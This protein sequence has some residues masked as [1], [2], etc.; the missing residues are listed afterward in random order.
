MEA[1]KSCIYSLG[2][3]SS[4]F[5]SEGLQTT[6]SSFLLKTL[7]RLIEPYLKSI[8]NLTLLSKAQHAYCKGKSTE[9]AFHS[10]VSKIETSLF[11]T[12]FGLC[13]FV[14]IEGAFNNVTPTAIT[15]A[16]SRLNINTQ[17]IELISS[18]LKGRI[19]SS[20][21]G[22]SYINKFVNRGTPQGA[23]NNVTTTASTS[24]PLHPIDRT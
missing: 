19:V 5:I 24:T 3:N 10:L 21:L 7:E 4:S 20:T 2:G 6:L 18:L 22:D 16:L 17:L 23:F 8:L 1:N 12:E 11:T 14:D 15:S 9:T 13:A